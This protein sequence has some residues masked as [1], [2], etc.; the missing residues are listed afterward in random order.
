[1]VKYTC[2][3]RSVPVPVVFVIPRPTSMCMVEICISC[4]ISDMMQIKENIATI[5]MVH[6]L[7]AEAVN[8]LRI[9]YLKPK[10]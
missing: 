5:M 9:N 6:F 3:F 4:N 8:A 7:S 10:I 1:M 2:T